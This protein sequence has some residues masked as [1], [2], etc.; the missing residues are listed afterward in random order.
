VATE[1]QDPPQD[2]IDPRD[3][4]SSAVAPSVEDGGKLHPLFSDIRMDQ[5][6]QDF[7]VSAS[8]PGG[9]RAHAR[10]LRRSD[11]D[12]ALIVMLSDVTFVAAGVL[13]WCSESP[14]V[15]ALV[16]APALLVAWPRVWRRRTTS[17]RR[18]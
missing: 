3:D 5:D 18:R 11:D 6:V 12:F 2:K 1:H 9:W 14:L 17:G 8:G 15:G 4:P 7:G 16:A 13:A 10:F